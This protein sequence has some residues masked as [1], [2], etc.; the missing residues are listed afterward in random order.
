M[1]DKESE[2]RAFGRS[3]SLNSRV[4]NCRPGKVALDGLRSWG[5]EA[6]PGRGSMA[7]SA[8]WFLP[9]LDPHIDGIGV[10]RIVKEDE[11]RYMA[12]SSPS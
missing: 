11:G 2:Y 4:E 8:A 7:A 5:G 1:A 9:R 3:S 10:P 12:V 6:V